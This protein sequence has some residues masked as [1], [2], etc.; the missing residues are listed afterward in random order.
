M[1]EPEFPERQRLRRPLEH[2]RQ[3][4][5]E[6][7]VNRVLVQRG[8]GGPDARVSVRRGYGAE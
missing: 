8:L 4:P 1:Y 5:L 6:P 7:L 2:I 3:I